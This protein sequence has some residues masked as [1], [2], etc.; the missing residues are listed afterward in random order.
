MWQA[1]ESMYLAPLHGRWRTSRLWR[2]LLTPHI[3]FKFKFKLQIQISNSFQIQI[4]NSGLTRQGRIFEYPSFH[5]AHHK[6]RCSDDRGVGAQAISP[7]NWDSGTLLL[8]LVID[9]W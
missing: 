2:G 1:Q 3:N 8:W 5:E 4:S 7:W 6:E 9:D